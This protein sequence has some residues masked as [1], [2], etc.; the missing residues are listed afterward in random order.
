M[1]TDD[2]INTRHEKD[3]I[4]TEKIRVRTNNAIKTET[5]DASILPI[6]VLNRWHPLHRMQIKLGMAS[7]FFNRR[8]KSAPDEGRRRS[9]GPPDNRSVLTMVVIIAYKTPNFRAEFSTT[10]FYRISPSLDKFKFY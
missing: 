4:I 9:S 5:T 7:F 3:R 8:L 2:P 1:K 10:P 6:V